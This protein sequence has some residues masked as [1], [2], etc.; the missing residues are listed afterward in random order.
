MTGKSI[1]EENKIFAENCGH[2]EKESNFYFLW[3][4]QERFFNLRSV[5][6]IEETIV[7]FERSLWRDEE[8]K[9][10]VP[11]QN[12]SAISN[13][14]SKKLLFHTLINVEKLLCTKEAYW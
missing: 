8:P 3:K 6:Q 7:T 14:T 11:L 13:F 2:F 1:R 10:D 4:V 5:W 12:I 9:I